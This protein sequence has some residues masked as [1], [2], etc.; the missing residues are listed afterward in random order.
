M[1]TI[2]QPG[3]YITSKKGFQITFANGWTVSVQFG[4][5]NYS[6]NH[7]A[8]IGHE[9]ELSGKRGSDTAEVAYFPAGGKLQPFDGGDT[10]QGYQT[11]AQVLALLNTVAQKAMS[12]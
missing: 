12:L 6:A 10:V 4:P 1:T 2:K 3:F 11:P 9:E 5:G 8:Q 7:D